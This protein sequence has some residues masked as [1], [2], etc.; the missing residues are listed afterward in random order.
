MRELCRTR[1]P[2]KDLLKTQNL[3]CEDK[4]KL[5]CDILQSFLVRAKCEKQQYI[6]LR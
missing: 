1:I 2:L 6:T 4:K 5:H 3:L